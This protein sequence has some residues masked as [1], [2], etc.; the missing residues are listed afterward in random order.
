MRMLD[1]EVV[2]QIVEERLEAMR[3]K[4]HE[5]S[6]DWVRELMEAEFDDRLDEEVDARLEELKEQVRVE[7]EEDLENNEDLKVSLLRSRNIETL[8]LELLR[9]E[10]SPLTIEQITE[11]IGYYVS[12]SALQHL[13]KRG[14]VHQPTV[15][16]W[17]AAPE[18]TQAKIEEQQATATKVLMYRTLTSRGFMVTA[19]EFGLEEK[20][21]A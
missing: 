3:H 17:A 5:E 6:A 18:E 19:A 15:N 10:S 20:D 4:V 16:F 2:D 8:I 1:Q 21:V 9:K 11:R 7:V 14:N 13:E 12:D